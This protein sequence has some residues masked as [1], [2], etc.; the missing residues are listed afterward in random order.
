[1]GHAVGW[2]SPEGGAA[3][4][5]E[6]LVGYLARSAARVRTSAPVTR[7]ARRARPRHRRRG[8]RARARRRASSSSPTSRPRGLLALAGDAL[9]GRYATE[10]RGYRHGPATLKVDWALSG[11]IPWTAPEAREA[12]TVHVGGSED[13]VLSA[14]APPAAA[15]TSKPFM[16]L[17]QQTVADPSRAPAGKHTAWAYTHGPRE[18][19][20][21]GETE[22]QVERMEAQVERF[23]PG[24]RDLILA[25]HVLL[26]GRPRAAQ[27][28]PRRRRRRRGLVLARP[29]RLPPASRSLSPY[30]TPVRGLFIGSAVDVPRRRGARRPRSRGRA[31][32]LRQAR[33][34]RP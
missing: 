2:P 20:W 30:S 26:P 25:R 9:D 21:A 16:L 33:M 22:R 29:G 11:P 24:F 28:E 14:L 23:A 13:E 6:A 18:A 10:L 3:R 27:R 7:V 12:G 1:M 34:R 17:G 4:L 8:R 31:A 32:A 19:D 5:A 15:C